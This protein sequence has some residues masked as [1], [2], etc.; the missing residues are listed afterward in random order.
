MKWNPY[1]PSKIESFIRCPYRASLIYGNKLE[2]NLN[3]DIVIVG[4]A[5]HNL[6]E[7]YIVGLNSGMTLEELEISPYSELEKLNVKLQSPHMISRYNLL[8]DNLLKWI[9][10][11]KELS[12]AKTEISIS[13]DKNSNPVEWNDKNGYLRGR[14]DVVLEK[15]NYIYVYDFKTGEPHYGYQDIIY[16]ILIFSL[17]E[18][19]DVMEMSYVPLGDIEY[20]DKWKFIYDRSQ[21]P[22]LKKIV[23]IKIKEIEKMDVYLPNPNEYCSNSNCISICPFR[24]SMENKDIISKYLYYKAKADQLNNEIKEIVNNE[25]T[26]VSTAGKF[27]KEISTSN[28]YKIIDLLEAIGKDNIQLLENITISK[29]DFIKISKK[30]KEKIII[31]PIVKKRKRYRFEQKIKE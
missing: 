22:E 27:Y 1:S 7:R 8:A 5:I 20:L 26:L 13:I 19:I 6:A 4:K 9:S 23:N 25:G 3:K 2:R 17:F 12:E 11:H 31:D 30:I 16:P 28:R 15:D 21:I 29:T 24:H 18:N 10:T 14:M